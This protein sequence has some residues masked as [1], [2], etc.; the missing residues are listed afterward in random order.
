MLVELPPDGPGP[1]L[2]V[3]FQPPQEPVANFV[4]GRVRSAVRGSVLG[5]LLGDALGATGGR[6]PTTGALRATS[7]GQLA[8]FTVEGMIRASIRSSHRGI[9]HAPSVVW[10]AYHRWATLQGIPAVRQW[11]EEN[12]PDGWLAG[13]PA[14]AERRGSAPATVAALQGQ[15]IGTV[16]K[17]AG[18]SLGA[19]ALSRTLPA[20]SAAQFL[21][22]P[23]QF[24]LESAA[25]THAVEA[26]DVSVV[27]AMLVSA[28]I[29][30]VPIREALPAVI[31]RCDQGDRIPVRREVAS[32]LTSA[33]VAES[34]D[35]ATLRSF[36]PDGRA[37]SA[38]AG[39]IYVVASFPDR[40]RTRD[41]LVF[42]ASAG[43][44]GHVATTAGALLGATHG[45][46]TL[47]VD[48]MSRL[49][50]GWVGDVLAQ[51]L[52]TELTEGPSGSEYEPNPDALWRDRYPGW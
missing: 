50:L 5:L 46:E 51:D 11:R 34:R 32:S 19:H 42:A 23:V 52:I 3:A 10:H 39:A 18:T 36:A 44:G 31:A 27:G 26:A 8:C 1:T 7:A 29:D 20:G 43:D 4:T 2:P 35:L 9:C 15:R 16:E 47:P 17:P 12:W 25:T 21:T 37:S 28:L 13:V 33:L 40:D 45:A 38:L 22:D 30:D 41:A 49:E 48:W 24:A 6:P 14:L